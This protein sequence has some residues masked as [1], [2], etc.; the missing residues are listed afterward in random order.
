MNGRLA[1]FPL[2]LSENIKWAQYVCHI[3]SFPYLWLLVNLSG[4]NPTDIKILR[5]V[6]R[7]FLST[8]TLVYKNINFLWT[9]GS[10]L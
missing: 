6:Q 4:P 5:I 8:E 1:S 10:Q 7:V 3:L 9:Q 2:S